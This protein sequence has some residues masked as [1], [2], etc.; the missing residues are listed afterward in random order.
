MESK[1]LLKSMILMGVG[2]CILFAFDTSNKVKV[3]TPFCRM[4]SNCSLFE[5]AKSS[6]VYGFP[7]SSCNDEVTTMV[8]IPN[9]KNINLFKN[10]LK[11][12]SM[13]SLALEVEQIQY[14]MH[15]GSG[16]T[17]T[18]SVR[19]YEKRISKDER[20]KEVVISFIRDLST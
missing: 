18:E 20:Y 7:V 8:F 4:Q 15:H 3:R 5:S 10:Y 6:T 1:T 11:G 14:D 17:Y 9:N 13:D 2:V 19:K 16:E 12:L